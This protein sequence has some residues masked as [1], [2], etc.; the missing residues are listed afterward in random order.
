MVES[1]DL[2]NSDSL[3]MVS[4]QDQERECKSKNGRDVENF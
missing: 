2:E 3:C 1:R 4:E